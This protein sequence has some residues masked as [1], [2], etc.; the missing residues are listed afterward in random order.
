MHSYDDIRQNYKPKRVSLLLVAESPPPASEVQSSRH[1][2]RS[3]KIRHEDRLFTNTIK[4][5]Y[6]EAANL[7]EAEIQPSKEAWLRRLQQDGVYM[8]E[9]LET[10]QQHNVTKKS[11]QSKI[12]EALPKLIERIRNLATPQTGI[13]LIKSNVYDVAAAPLKEAGFNVLNT[14]LVDYPGRYN[15]QAYREKL[16]KLATRVK[17][18]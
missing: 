17:F 18:S 4:A 15:Q 3:D 14:G 12:H 2:Y 5:L 6:A 9:A 8:I 11:R 1:F 13:V 16:A 10:S 7:T